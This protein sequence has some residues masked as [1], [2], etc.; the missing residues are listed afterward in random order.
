MNKKVSK[1]VSSV[2]DLLAVI[3]CLWGMAGMCGLA[4][5]LSFVGLEPIF[6][7]GLYVGLPSF[8]I[9]ILALIA[10]LLTYQ[11]GKPQTQLKMAI[12]GLFCGALE[13][14]AAFALITYIFT[15]IH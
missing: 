8:A 7:I 5:G 1:M 6:V 15:S 13:I 9:G 11:A 2:A 4:C 10:G 12:I 3:S 14:A